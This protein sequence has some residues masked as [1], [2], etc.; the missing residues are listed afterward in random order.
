LWKSKYDALAKIY[1]QLRHEHLDLLGKFKQ[2]QLKAASAEEAI[3][4][5]EKLEREMKSKNLELADMIRERDRALY[6]L[7]RV[8]GEQKD[9][10][11]SLKRE[12]RMTEEKVKNQDSSKGRELSAMLSRHNREVA[13]LEELLRSKQRQIDDLNSRTS[14]LSE[15]L[16]RQ[17]KDK[18]EELEVYKAGMDQVLLEV[19]N[20]QKIAASVR[21]S[22]SQLWTGADY[23]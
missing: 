9:E 8:K 4:K 3:E 20:A 5:R 21:L 23:Q 11:E 6:N 14:D 19:N 15:D 17:L 13:D 1:S 16:Q 7:D 12:L 10:V 18:E 2:Q 22:S